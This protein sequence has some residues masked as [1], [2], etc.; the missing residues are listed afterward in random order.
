M[1]VSLAQ[2]RIGDV[3]PGLWVIRIQ[4]FLRSDFKEKLAFV[5]G[6]SPIAFGF[7]SLDHSA[8]RRG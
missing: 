4:T 1:Y 6:V 8:Q 3:L 2:V 7:M 5:F